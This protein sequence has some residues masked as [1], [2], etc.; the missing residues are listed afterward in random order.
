MKEKF[1]NPAI[2]APLLV[3][4]IIIAMQMSKFA[5]KN[6]DSGTNIFVAVG[7]IQLVAMGLPC[8]I[9]YLMKNRRLSDPIYGISTRGP[10]ILFVI[11]AALFFVCGTLL[12]K[13]FYILGGAESAALVNFYGEITQTSTE[14]RNIE[15]LLSLV[16]IPAVCEELFFRG[17]I[18][19]EYRRFG[20][21]NAVIISAVCFAMLHFSLTNFFVYLFSGLVFGFVTAMTR[22]ILPSVALH[23]LSNYLSIYASDA[24]LRITVIKN[25]AYFIGFVLVML[26][27]LCF[28]LLMSRVETVCLNYSDRPPVESI[29]PKSSEHWA[30]VVF[31][32]TFIILIIVFLTVSLFI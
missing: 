18:F 16:I 7:V 29:P 12:V 4:G 8:I 3:I 15:I 14:A 31:S 9:Y 11:F 2:T 19:S 26:T 6:L 27:A 28:I 25:G 5:L 17:I 30:E 22:S 23:L 10:Q 20:T 24:F 21:A 1:K 32:P 13:F